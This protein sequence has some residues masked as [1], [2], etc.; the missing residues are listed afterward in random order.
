MKYAFIRRHEQ[1]FRVTRMCAVL[2]VSSSTAENELPWYETPSFRF[3]CLRLLPKNEFGDWLFAVALFRHWHGRWPKR[4]GGTINDA[5]FRLKTSADITNPLRV[6]VS[7]K[8]HV[9]DYVRARLGDEFNVATIAC[10]KSWASVKRFDFPSRCVIKPTHLSGAV[11]MRKRGEALDLL[12]LKKWFKA[13]FYDHTRERNYRTLV[14]KIIVEPFVF[15][16]EMPTHHKIYCYR[17]EPRMILTRVRAAAEGLRTF[18][19]DRWNPQPIHYVDDKTDAVQQQPPNGD[20]LLHVARVL[21]NEFA[22]SKRSSLIRVDLYSDGN[23]VKVGELTN[24][25]CG[26]GIMYDSPESELR[27]TRLLFGDGPHEAIVG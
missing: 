19:D 12:A 13:N 1:L 24:C 23:Q 8:E 25:P 22:F 27:A 16:S 3:R 4:S 20:L 17:G 14:P 9:K 18:F 10:L 7:D 26:A 21:S 5:L 11:V 15:D 2:D 6:Y